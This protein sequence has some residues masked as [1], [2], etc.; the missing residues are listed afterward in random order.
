MVMG[1]EEVGTRI[2]GYCS[3]AARNRARQL[4]MDDELFMAIMLTVRDAEMASGAE[5]GHAAR[6]RALASVGA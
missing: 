5:A 6:E 3:E 4:L 1:R 2:V